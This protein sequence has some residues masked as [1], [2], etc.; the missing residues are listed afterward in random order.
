MDSLQGLEALPLPLI[1]RLRCAHCSHPLNQ[2][3]K[4]DADTS[5]PYCVIGTSAAPSGTLSGRFFNLVVCHDLF[6][7]FER[8][9]IVVAPVIARYPGAQV[10]EETGTMRSHFG[11]E[12]P[13]RG[14]CAMERRLRSQRISD[15]GLYT[16]VMIQNKKF[17]R[18][19]SFSSQPFPSKPSTPITSAERT[20][21]A[22]RRVIQ[23]VYMSMDIS[24]M[25]V[26]LWNYPGQAFSE[27]REQ[28]LL[29]NEYLATILQYL[30]LHLGSKSKGGT[31]EE[32]R[33]E[34]VDMLLS[35]ALRCFIGLSN[36][37]SGGIGK[38]RRCKCD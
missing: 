30:L 34:C 15:F 37:S 21:V 11:D 17:G 10:F 1:R 24:D 26:L 23:Q 16:H 29:N 25:Q 3:S 36:N 20:Y 4:V 8:M 31:G 22:K 18:Q 12:G 14:T 27:W 13:R 9:K 6:D 28:Q 2:P 33:R 32:P 7:N 35:T 38:R 19:S 5:V